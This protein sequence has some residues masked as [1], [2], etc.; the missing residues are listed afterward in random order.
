MLPRRS[1]SNPWR[2]ATMRK[3]V[4]FGLVGLSFLT[5]LGFGL[6]P[7]MQAA[8]NTRPH[9]Q[10]SRA[11]AKIQP[12]L[13]A[14]YGKLPLSFEANQGQTDARVRFLARG[15]G[16][17]IFLTDDEAVLTLRRSSVISGQS[18]VAPV[19]T[20]PG[21]NQLGKRGGPGWVEPFGSFDPRAGRWPSLADGWGRLWPSLI[22]DISQMVPELFTDKGALTKGRESQPPRVV[23]MRLEGGSATGLVVGLNELPGRSNYFIG[24][25]PGKWRT[26]VPSYAKVKYEGV[27]PGVD[28]VYYGNQRQ[29]EY[30]F[31]V[32]P[33]ADPNQIML[34]FVGADGMRV[35]AASGD[36][37]LK[38][39]D[40]EV[41]FHKPAVYQPPREVAS[42]SPSNFAAT[43]S[44]RH[45][46]SESAATGE[47]GGAF[48]V[49]SNNQVSFRV[50]GYDPRRALVIDPVLSYSTYLGGSDT[51]KGTGIAVDSSGNAYVTGS[52]LST[53]FP[54]ADALQLVYGGSGDAFVTKLNA[55]G[56]AL[57]YSTYLGGSNDDLGFAIAVDSSGNAYVTG[58]TASTNFPTVDPNQPSNKAYLTSGNPTA[59]VAKLSSTGS[60]LVYSTYLGGSVADAGAGIAV[61]STNNAYVTGV[62]ESDDFPTLNPPQASLRGKSNAFLTKL[63]ATGSALVYSTFLGGG[64][65]DAA[66]G[67]AVDSSGNAYVTGNT[68]STNFPTVNPFQATNKATPTTEKPTAFVTK[69][70]AAGSA[71]VYSTYLGGNKWDSGLGIAV[72]SSGNAYVTGLTGS[73][74]FPV[75]NPFQATNKAALANASNN[76]AFVATLNS[77]GSALVYSTYLGGSDWDSGNA[78]AVDSSG[79]A[80]VAGTTYSTD[81]PTL[82]AVQATCASC[83]TDPDAFVTELKSTGAVLVYSTYLGGSNV[84]DGQGIALD[85][86]GDAYVTGVTYSADFPV[87]TQIPGACKGT[88][89]SGGEYGDAFVS[90]IVGVLAPAAS[91][92][93]DSLTFPSQTVNT[94]SAA[95]SVTLTNTGNAPLAISQITASGEFALATTETTCSTSVPVAAGKNCTL[96]VTFTPTATGT[97]D[98][99]ITITDNSTGVA[100]SVQTVTLSGTGAAAAPLAVVNPP[101]LTFPGQNVGTTSGWQAVTLS[102]MTGSASLSIASIVAS[103]NFGENDNCDG[104]VVVGG[105]CTIY[106]TFS[107]TA[108]GLLAG[109]LTLTDNSDGV[110]GSTQTV[111]LTGTG[112][113][114]APVA[115]VS[116]SSLTFSNQTVGTTSAP[117]PVTLSNTGSAALTIAS[118]TAS[119]NFGQSNNCAGSVAVSGSCTINVTFS[120]TATGATTGTLTI[121]DNS[122]GVAGSTQTVQLSEAGTSQD[123]TLVAASGSSTTVTVGPGTAASYTLSVGGQ[124]GFSGA[125]A[126]TCTGAPAGATCTVWPNKVSVGS[127]ATNVSVTVTTTTTSSSVP[128]SL[129]FPPVPPLSPGLTGLAMLALILAGMAW[130]IRRRNQPGISRWQA[131]MASLASAA[132]LTLALAGC[133]GG[134]SSSVTPPPTTPVTPAGTYTLTVTG[135]SGSGSTALSHSVTLTLTVS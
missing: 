26:N 6:L 130:A 31:V 95:Q 29:L 3:V 69:L 89:G 83:T 9:P 55:T 40:G 11:L 10:P 34:S 13:V 98:G 122:N 117:Q 4:C 80:Y 128:H 16:Y 44:D 67:I 50:M 66:A 118:I 38:V 96:A 65:I 135:T 45:R 86:S 103:A 27:Y 14:R 73:T 116:P 61:D 72:D 111:N 119:A 12:Q 1:V 53:D 110:T 85:V 115:G 134:G 97:Q 94:T 8:E 123:F 100:G 125:V 82:K 39:G 106:V 28:L 124:G 108:A 35:D 41:R 46:R 56:S 76:T 87:V 68:T 42:S 88:C 129:P 102:N 18:S 22:P 17:A 121:A 52:T 32:Q 47:L 21:M 92:S 133:G 75:V 93:S 81:F 54:T 59:F 7:R 114:P 58:A 33:G 104:S 74:N 131:A 99:A 63:K 20:R 109:T 113:T 90:M 64:G 101:S 43:I 71:F 84:D 48:V 49:A 25:D 91:L 60:A 36:L 23:R 120:P 19:G 37:V 132:V 51:D 2:T 5:V 24:N 30:D 77:T 79:N 107:P 127:S 126:F 15:G 57:V 112:V 62:T 70:N 78:I 105:S